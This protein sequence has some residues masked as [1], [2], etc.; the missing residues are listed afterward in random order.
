MTVAVTVVWQ[1]SVVLLALAALLIAVERI[2]EIAANI[3]AAWNE[4]I[5]A[6]LE[7]ED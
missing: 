1:L 6:L 2:D 3:A 4:L 7:L 5:N